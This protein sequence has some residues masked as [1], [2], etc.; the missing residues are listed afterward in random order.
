MVKINI[1]FSQ[2]IKIY[3]LGQVNCHS[4]SNGLN[5]QKAILKAGDFFGG[6]ALFNNSSN[7]ATIEAVDEVFCL[8]ISRQLFDSELRHII[9]QLQQAEH[10]YGLFKNQL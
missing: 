6:Q 5:V 4:Q 2:L 10:L 1:K 9:N 8:V 3:A 7:I